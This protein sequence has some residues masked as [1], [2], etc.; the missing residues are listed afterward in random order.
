MRT[1][2]EGLQVAVNALMMAM[3]MSGLWLW[4]RLRQTKTD[5]L[6]TL[7]R[8][9]I[10]RRVPW[11]RIWSPAHNDDFFVGFTSC[12]T[13]R[14]GTTSRPRNR[15]AFIAGD[16]AIAV[17]EVDGVTAYQARF[18]SAVEPIYECQR[19][20]ENGEHRYAAQALGSPFKHTFDIDYGRINKFL[21]VSSWQAVDPEHL[22]CLNHH[23]QYYPKYLSLGS[24]TN[25]NVRWLHSLSW[26]PEPLRTVVLF[27]LA[28]SIFV[29][30]ALGVVLF[31]PRVF[32]QQETSDYKIVSHLK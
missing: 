13:A 27:L 17:V 30:T 24:G 18:S 4:W 20:A 11:C 28:M 32:F 16:S 5:A 7:H 29:S 23:W 21:P 3:A 12:T 19:W 14:L 6:R 25:K 2:R 31:F 26:L 10:Y 22:A 9:G 1:L 8:R 15:G